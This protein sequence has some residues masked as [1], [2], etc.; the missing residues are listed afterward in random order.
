P[1]ADA[2]NY[3]KNNLY[4]DVGDESQGDVTSVDGL[5]AGTTSK[6]NIAFAFD[7]ADSNCYFKLL[8]N[9]KFTNGN[10]K[11]NITV[12][13]T[14]EV[15]V[16][17]DESSEA[18]SSEEPSSEEPSSEEPSSEEPSSEPDESSEEPDGASDTYVLVESDDLKS[19]D[20]IILVAK[21][22]NGKNFASGAF[23]QKYIKSA[24]VTVSED[25]K[26]VVGSTS[27]VAPITLQKTEDVWT[28]NFGEKAICTDA[29]KALNIE[30]KGSCY[31]TIPIDEDTHIATVTSAKDGCGRFL[32]NA[33]ATRFVNYT[34]NTSVSMIL[35]QIYKLV[36]NKEEEGVVVSLGSKVK[37][38]TFSLRLGAKYNGKL[39]SADERATVTDL[40]IVF[41][42]SKF[43]KE[44]DALDLTTEGAAILSATGIDEDYYVD[45]KAFVDYETFVFYATSSISPKTAEIPISPS[46]RISSTA[47]APF[48]AKSSQEIITI[49]S[50][51]PA[52]SRSKTA[53]TRFPA[54]PTG[55][56]DI[57]C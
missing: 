19:G 26:I 40:G 50:P 13:V 29:A 20:K 51:L 37:T 11:G 45:G 2:N 31:W 46:A 53:R 22:K 43:L 36:E 47:K 41:Y 24:E 49:L 25:N 52:K 10:I 3:F 18:E 28:L 57:A 27:E 38:S 56:T 8:T 42:P 54:R 9:E 17:G 39:L 30:N 6:S 14:Y 4:C 44:A 48:T 1:D 5:T 35:P 32:Y 34:S 23:E 55:L 7:S 21:D 16:P 15:N 12:T 33:D